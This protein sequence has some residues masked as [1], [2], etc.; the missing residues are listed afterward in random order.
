MSLSLSCP[1]GARFEV[2]ESFARQTV[3]CPEC[4]RAVQ[5]PAAV[6]RRPVRTSGW[7]VAAA[8]LAL[9]LAFTGIGT[10]LAVILGVIALVS[11]A[12]NRG[13][14]T[15]TGFAIF[16]IVWGIAFTGLFVVAMARGELFGVGDSVRER[17]M[18]DEVESKGPLEVRRPEQGFVITRPSVKWG[19][20]KPSLALK[21]TEN[22][23]ELLLVNLSKDAYIDVENEWLAGRSFDSLRDEV[24]RRFRDNGA[25]N[26]LDG[27]SKFRPKLT[28]LTVRQNQRL[29]T[30]N[31]MDQAELLLDV[32]VGGAWMTFLIRLLKHEN[33]NRVYLIRAWA[34]RRRFPEVEPDIR[35]AM[36]SF[37]VLDE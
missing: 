1:C 19:V 16:S 21:L 13:Q 4:Q 35:R 20:A 14:V 23:D 5:A 15:G 18:G 32:R 6:S 27:K 24:V 2:D 29:P 8:V 17:L 28:D 30:A 31:G 36:D 33:S 22:S 12:R 9:V 37:R 26:D 3:A 25:L 34:Q 10:I 7:A 11:I